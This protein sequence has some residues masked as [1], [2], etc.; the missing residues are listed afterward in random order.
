MA[1]DKD[2]SKLSNHYAG[3]ICVGIDN[4]WHYWTVN[5]SQ[6]PRLEHPSKKI[7]KLISTIAVNHKAC[8]K[9]VELMLLKNI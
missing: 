9:A 4:D 2:A 5:H 8:P 6:A 1:T 7:Q 3:D